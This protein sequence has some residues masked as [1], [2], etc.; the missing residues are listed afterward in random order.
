MMKIETTSP[1]GDA[2]RLMV[3]D[4]LGHDD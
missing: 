2:L 4:K 1:K 3:S